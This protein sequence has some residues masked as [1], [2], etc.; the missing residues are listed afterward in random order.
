M[1]PR[2]FVG[3]LL[4]TCVI[5]LAAPRPSSGQFV[6]T[7]VQY[8]VL[9]ERTDAFCNYYKEQTKGN[10][11]FPTG[12]VSFPGQGSVKWVFTASEAQAFIKK[13]DR[14]MGLMQQIK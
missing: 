2:R 10:K 13:C 5:S 4:V 11:P 9:Q 14:L 6:F 3:L 1:T 12:A 7:I 8:I